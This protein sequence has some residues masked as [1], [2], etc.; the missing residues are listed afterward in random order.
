MI[1]RNSNQANG[2]FIDAISRFLASPPE[3]TPSEVIEAFDMVG[4]REFLPPKLFLETVEQAPVAISIADPNAHILYVNSAFE[5][6]TGYKRDEVLGKNESVLSSKSTPKSVYEDLWSTIR[7]ARVW[8][9]KLVNHRKDKQEYLAELVISP[10][11]NGDGKIAYFLGMHRDMTVLHRLEQQLKFQKELTEASLDAAP[12][13][14]ALVGDD[15]KVLLD[16]HAYKALMGDFRGTEPANLILDAL[17]QQLEIDLDKFC[18]IENFTNVD[19]RLDPPSGAEPRWF[20]CSGVR[21]AELDEAAR[22]YFRRPG[23]G[24]CCLLLVANEVTGSRKRI[25]EARLNMMRAGMAEQQ[26]LQ[27][28]REAISGAIFKLQL[29]LNIIR[30]ALAM[31]ES[32]VAHLRQ[33]MEQA[34]RS[35]EEAMESLHISL[36]KPSSE[37]HSA[38]NVNE[39]VHEVLNL[40]TDKLLASGVVVDWRPTAVLPTFKGRVNALR[41]LFKYLIDN[42]IT[43]VNEAEHGYREIRIET[44][45]ENQ[46]QDQEL[47]IDVMDNGPGFAPSIR[48]KAFEPFYCGWASAG[49]HAGMG[50]TM[51]QEIAISH[52]GG[53]SVDPDFLGGCRV[54]VRLPLAVSRGDFLE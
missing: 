50:L 27:T 48:L 52:G 35:G 24:R 33:V 53:I 17:Q 8:Q 4:T 22:N 39:V 32:N 19:V 43:A 26:M 6:L 11:L 7:G 42:A 21:L 49:E 23:D 12:M 29:P 54:R 41:G 46:D 34:L 44:R 30:A 14:V 25:N 28:T 31:S 2:E 15:G 18:E 3:G 13:V 5:E 47:V 45:L 40:S 51:A 10:V 9:G 38:V 16:N 20:A 37:Q 36:P 1:Q